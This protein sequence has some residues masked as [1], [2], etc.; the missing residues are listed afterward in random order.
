MIGQ[1]FAPNPG[2]ISPFQLI[3]RKFFRNKDWIETY[4]D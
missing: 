4:F 2:N 1:T 3:R